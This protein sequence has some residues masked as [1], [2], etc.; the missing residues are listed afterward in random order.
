M[1]TKKDQEQESAT[2]AMFPTGVRPE[3]IEMEQ[4]LLI[5][6]SDEARIERKPPASPV[7]E[8]LNRLFRD[9]RAIVSLGII[10]FFILLAIVGPIIYQHIGAPYVDPID[11]I[12]YLPSTYHSFYFE[13]LANQGLNP[14]PMYWLGT[15]A[16]GRDILA[17]LMQGILIS[18]TVALL[19]EV[20]DVGVGVLVGV[21]AGFYGGWIDQILARFTD[22]MF[23][24]PGLLLVI[25][26]AGIFGSEADVLFAHVPVIGANGDARLLLVSLVLA[27]TAWPLMARYVRGQ[28]LQLKEQQFIEAARTSGTKNTRIIWRHIVPNLFSIVI[29]AATLN[30]ANT[31]VGEAG[32]SLLGLGVQ[33]PGSSIGLMISFAS[34]YISLDPWQVLVPATVLALLVVAFSFLGDGL[35]DAF[36]PRSKD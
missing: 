12:T 7:R 26:I 32:I 25:L 28:T 27:F 15:D 4:G 5:P 2:S 20:V 14:T 33:D 10:G 23:A 17:R 18:I 11:G 30:I 19:V 31:I 21:L 36:D 3:M 29:V 13:A 22:V 1:D 8:S 35:R 16:L 9:V 34:Q 24:F 6:S